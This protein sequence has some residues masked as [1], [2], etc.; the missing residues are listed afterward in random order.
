MERALLLWIIRASSMRRL[1]AEVFSL[2]WVS[3]TKVDNSGLAPRYSRTEI[4]HGVAEIFEMTRFSV[5]WIKGQWEQGAS[6]L[7]LKV[8]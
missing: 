1:A 4:S 3:M 7:V 2:L 8:L 5:P 6:W